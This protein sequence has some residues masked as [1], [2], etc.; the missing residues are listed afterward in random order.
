MLRIA[1]FCFLLCLI[2]VEAAT[3]VVPY[4]VSSMIKSL[5]FYYG[6]IKS[7]ILKHKPF[8]IQVSI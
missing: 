7:T 3:K 4:R 8:L 5:L 6:H 2:Q 1:E